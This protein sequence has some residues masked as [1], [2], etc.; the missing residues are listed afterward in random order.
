MTI[1]TDEVV[2]ITQANQ[3]FSAVARKVDVQGRVVIFKNNRPTYVLYKLD[4][5]P[6]KSLLEVKQ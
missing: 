4:S 2:S 3:N 5:C 6:D 1:N